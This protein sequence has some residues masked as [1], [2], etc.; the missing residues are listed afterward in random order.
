MSL[1]GG[2]EI[3]LLGDGLDL[4]GDGQHLQWVFG[5]LRLGGIRQRGDRGDHDPERGDQRAAPIARRGEVD[6]VQGLGPAGAQ[7]ARENF[8]VPNC[9]RFG[10]R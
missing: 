1:L 3:A 9:G 5:R 6:E 7:P 2:G 10:L 4:F 8:H